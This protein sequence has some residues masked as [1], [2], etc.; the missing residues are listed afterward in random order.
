MSAGDSRPGKSWTALSGVLGKRRAK[1]GDSAARALGLRPS[2]ELVFFPED[3]SEVS[4]VINAARD[5]GMPVV[6]VGTGSRIGSLPNLKLPA[7]SYIGL[8]LGSLTGVLEVQPDSLWMTVLA[9]TPWREIISSAAKHGLRPVGAPSAGSLGGWLSVCSSV[10][11]IIMGVQTPPVI[12]LE[13][14]LPTGNLVRSV[15]TP[16][17]AMGPDIFSL[18]LG[19]WGGLGVI[20]S[21][22]LRLEP[23][24]EK[25][26]VLG[27]RVASVAAAVRL[28]KRAARDFLPPRGGMIRLEIERDRR[29]ARLALSYQGA[30]QIV[31]ACEKFMLDSCSGKGIERASEEEARSWIADGQ[32]VDGRLNTAPVSWSHLP[33]LLKRI[34]KRLGRAS[35]IMIDRPQ[36]EGCRLRLTVDEPW[37][38]DVWCKLVDP[39]GEAQAS[40]ETA[41]SFMSRVRAELDPQGL[42]NPHAW[43]LPWVGGEG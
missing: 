43:P 40:L 34:D 15:T 23:L 37:A 32:I 25:E 16:R 30:K 39:R 26:A 14:V 3:P 1:R 22:T 27:W 31:E 24:P 8:G 11:D 42:V 10:D 9:G 5:E 35:R 13:A 7:G 18:F 38:D 6:T 17:A 33:G 36:I 19:T 12:G 21:A 41:R 2:P 29:R 20:T 4:I 28:L